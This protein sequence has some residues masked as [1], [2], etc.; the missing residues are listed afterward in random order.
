MLIESHQDCA[1][2]PDAQ[3]SLSGDSSDIAPL[4]RALAATT[5]WQAFSEELRPALPRLMPATRLDIYAIESDDTATLR[6][7]SSGISIVPPLRLASTDVQIRGWI[8]HQ[9]YSTIMMLPLIAAGRPC[10]WLAV[11]RQRGALPDTT[12]SL[13]ELLAPTIAMRLHADQ[14]DATLAKHRAHIALIEQQLAVTHTLRIRAMLAVG[15]AHDIGNLFTTVIGHTQML[16]Q[17]VPPLFQPDL[18]VILHA[19]EDGR[20]LLRRLQ[21]VK[22]NHE[23]TMYAYTPP[24]AIIQDTIVL[25]RPFWERRSTIT[26]ETVFEHT[27]AVNI[28]ATDLREI[29]VNLIMN[30]VAAMPAGGCITIRCVAEDDHVFISV[31]DTGQGIAREYHSAIFQPLTTTH[32]DGNGLGLSVS[33]ALVESHGGTLAVESAPGQGATF[34][35]T[36]P[37]I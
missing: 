25:T 17:D 2:T 32:A 7:S 19:A 27:P 37:T 10:G 21:D 5:D 13:A 28:P 35:L 16:E 11:A 8:E 9:G 30:A 18:R 20:R 33:R 22:A 1:M 26:I 29:L 31:T 6:F 24:Q 3:R 4:L 15:T 14:A 12:M 23:H 34:T 36:L